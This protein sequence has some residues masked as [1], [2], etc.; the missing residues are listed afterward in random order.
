[1]IQEFNGKT[2]K[3]RQEIEIPLDPPLRKGDV[4]DS[5][6]RKGLS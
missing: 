2:I 4:L 1:M 6:S 3:T 5:L